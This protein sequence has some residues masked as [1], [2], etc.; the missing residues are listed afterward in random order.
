MIVL[1]YPDRRMRRKAILKHVNRYKIRISDE[2]IDEIVDITKWYSLA[3]VEAF[4]RLAAGKG[5]GRITENEIKWTKKKFNISPTERASVQEYLRW[6]AS[7]VQGVV[8]TYIPSE[9][10]I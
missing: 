9:N 4:I 8:I 6:W 10:E 7:K 1:G 5:E 2:L 3:E